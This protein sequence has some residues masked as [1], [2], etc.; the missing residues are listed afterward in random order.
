MAEED[1]PKM[2]FRTHHGHYE[3]RVMPFGLCN[4]PSTFQAIMNVVLF[5]VV[6]F[7][8]ILVY[9]VS[10]STHLEHLD[11]VL[12]TLL[13]GKFYLK[14]SKCL[15]AQRQLEYLGHIILGNGIEPD[16]SKVV[17]MIQWPI[18]SSQKDLRSFLGLIGFYQHFIKGCRLSL[19]SYVVTS[20]TSHRKLNKLSTT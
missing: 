17:A 1:I 19:R 5:V 6:F 11:M 8:N 18:P 14:H 15:F 10:L 7:N 20:F 9:C 16:P 3:Y 2:A 4:T 13:Q 12:Q